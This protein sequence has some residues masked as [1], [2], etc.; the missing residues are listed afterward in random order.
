MEAGENVI[1]HCGRVITLD[2]F[3]NC[4][5]KSVV[6]EIREGGPGKNK[7]VTVDGIRV[8]GVPT[9]ERYDQDK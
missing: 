8:E 2:Q 9:G 6:V 5:L 4:A 7:I 1:I 3:L